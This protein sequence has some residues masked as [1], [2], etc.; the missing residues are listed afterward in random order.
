VEPE[1]WEAPSL[2]AGWSVHHVVAHVVS[3]EELSITALAARFL[4]GRLQVDRVNSIGVEDYVRRPPDELVRLLRQHL[5]PQG[6]TSGFGG[7]IAL[8]DGL[9][10]HQDIRRALGLARDVPAER[11]PPALGMAL[12]APTLPSRSKVR[13]LR[14]V[15]T[16]LEWSTGRGLEVTAPAEALLMAIAGREGALQDIAGPGAT[17]LADRLRQ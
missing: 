9:I 16:D 13:G 10:H 11:L 3:Y 6:I 4:R 5:T 17:V 12:R 8:T 1:Q 14:L 2:C 7:R 15:A